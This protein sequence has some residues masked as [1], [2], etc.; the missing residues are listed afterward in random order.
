MTTQPEIDDLT[1]RASELTEIVG[2]EHAIPCLHR[3]IN[4][5][6][7]RSQD[8]AI[9]PL[10]MTQF[11]AYV[12]S[13]RILTNY[14]VKERRLD[15]VHEMASWEFL[16]QFVEFAGLGIWAVEENIAHHLAYRLASARRI[17]DEA[18][19]WYLANLATHLF[20]EPP[21]NLNDALSG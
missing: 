5:L 12:T 15:L 3:L 11:G 14:A 18:A 7:E 21:S 1:Q 20:P 2:A 17:G 4:T 10:G 19:D 13:E 6:A 9:V 8:D 16:S